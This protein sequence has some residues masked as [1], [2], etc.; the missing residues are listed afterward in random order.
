MIA[1]SLFHPATAQEAATTP[2]PE[3]G[4]AAS[5]YLNKREEKRIGQMFF[6]RLLASPKYIDDPELRHYINQLGARVGSATNL[7]ELKLHFSL[8]KESSLNAFAVPGGYITFHTGLILTTTTESELASV[9]GHEIAHL[10][11][12]HLPRMIAKAEA[13]KLPTTAAIIASILIGGQAGIAG[14]TLANANLLANQLAYSR[15]FEKEADAIGIQLMS[16]SGFDPEATSSFF[17]KLQRFT[18]VTSKDVPEFL[19]SHPLSYT[20]VAEAEA[21]LAALPKQTHASSIEFHFTKAKI[22]ALFTDRPEVAQQQL[23][24]QISETSGVENQAAKY[25]LALSLS[26]QRKYDEAGQLLSDLEKALPEQIS[27]LIAKSD[28]LRGSGQVADG[29]ELLTAL[30]NTHKDQHYVA[31]YLIDALLDDNQFDLAKRQT[32]YQLRR[33]PDDFR[34]FRKLSKANVGLGNLAEA[35][36]ADA[37]YLAAIGRYKAAVSSLKLA[38]RDNADKSSYLKQSIEARLK[39]F[40]RLAS[41]EKKQEKES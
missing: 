30:V 26:R 17:E 23:R 34:L 24:A 40:D 15:E 31:H 21:R 9:V 39:D 36:Q 32:R 38:L 28:V 13:T 14:V 16:R 37:E 18:L 7:G 27:I 20:R 10:S 6:R 19:R 41:E 35:H 1:F 2:L 8:L 29:I 3:L 5:V 33:Y 11:Q 4:D 25:G 22:R 12:R